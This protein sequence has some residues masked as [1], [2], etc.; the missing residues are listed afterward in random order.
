MATT[1]VTIATEL[2]KYLKDTERTSAPVISDATYNAIILENVVVE[3]TTWTFE[4]VATN[5]YRCYELGGKGQEPVFL[6][7]NDTSDPLGSQDDALGTYVVSC[8]G[9]ITVSGIT[10]D[11]TSFTVTGAGVD[12]NGCLDDLF[13]MREAS[14][15]CDAN[16]SGI[17]GSYAPT[18]ESRIR[19]FRQHLRGAH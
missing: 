18:E 10:E 5:Q 12:F 13:K 2:Q 8:R 9:T 16:Q 6:L 19:L 3:D 17:D 11:A 4:K 7:F 14:K 15:T 1:V